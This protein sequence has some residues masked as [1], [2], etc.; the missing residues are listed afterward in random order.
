MNKEE[1]TNQ[2]HNYLAEI[3]DTQE[4]CA[5][6][7]KTPHYAKMGQ[8]GI[9]AIVASAKSLNMNPIQAL[10]GGLYFVK[11]KVEMTSRTMGALIRSR[12]HSFT[13]D[14]RSNDKVCILHGKRSDTKDCWT[15][16]FSMEEAKK[17]GLV[18]Q[19]GPWINYPRDMLFA[20]ALSRLARQLFP[21]VI[22]NC[23]VEG[24]IGGD[25]N[26]KEI[27]RQDDGQ[28]DRV[29]DKRTEEE[30]NIL[31]EELK[32]V[33]GYRKEIENFLTKNEITDFE[34]MPKEMYDKVLGRAKEKAKEVA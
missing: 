13:K 28:D 19:F 5:L 24:E 4:M 34:N 31:V 16:S 20:R 30:V 6:L 29:P 21:D 11:G 33:P 9:F 17:A 8:E 25:D 2:P 7:M 14:A 22:G 27:T 10:M 3:K 23:Y 32:K 26:I 18:K 15:E 12:N 1:I